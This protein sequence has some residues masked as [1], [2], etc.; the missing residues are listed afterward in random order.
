ME[1]EVNKLINGLSDKDFSHNTQDY[2]LKNV[3]EKR[4]T[5]NAQSKVME[6]EVN[7]LINGLSDKDFPYNT[8]DYG[9]KSRDFLQINYLKKEKH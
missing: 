5:L 2:G 1:T 9:L 3:N 8:Q 6:T 4:R 7:K